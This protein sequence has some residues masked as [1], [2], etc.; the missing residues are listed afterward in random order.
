MNIT[1]TR[2]PGVDGVAVSANFGRSRITQ[3]PSGS[4]ISAGPADETSEEQSCRRM[5]MDRL[6]DTGKIYEGGATVVNPR[7]GNL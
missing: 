7:E 1:Y 2:H 3:Y 5:L 4:I 6:V